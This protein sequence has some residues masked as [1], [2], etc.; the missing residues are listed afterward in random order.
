MI[1]FLDGILTEKTPGRAVVCAG[2]VG[3]AADIPLSTYDRLPEE[4]AHVRILTVHV[5]RE[6]DERLFGF[7]TEEERDLFRLLTGVSGI[8]P[9]MGLAVLSGMRPVDFIAAVADEDARRL[10]GINGI[11]KKLAERLVVEMRNKLPKGMLLAAASGLAGGGEQPLADA[12]LRDA[13]HALAA[14][15]YK[16]VEA[17]VAA[18]EAVAKLPETADVEEVLRVV[19]RNRGRGSG[20]RS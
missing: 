7:A 1:V 11:G 6:D 14:L 12:R 19:L 15:G 9:K 3:Y 17:A 5:V 2:G 8:G 4:G 20:R 10:T 13:V 16:P 18:K